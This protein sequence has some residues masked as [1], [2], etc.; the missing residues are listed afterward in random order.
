MKI[1]ITA[2]ITCQ[3][4]ATS[5]WGQTAPPKTAVELARYMGIDRERLLYDGAKKEGKVVWYTSLTVYKE[6]AR[7]FET[8]YPGVAVEVYRAPAMNLVSRI[9]SETQSRRSIVDAIETTPGSLMLVRDNKLLLPYNSPHL[10]DYPDGSKDKAP[11]GLFFTT[12][13]RESYAGIGYNKNVIPSA[14]VPKN[15]D[16]LLKPS[17]KGKLGI[18]G[19]EIGT[20]MIGAMLKEKGEGFV[21]KLAA[22]DIRHYAL[23]ALGLN[24]LVVSGEVPL[25]FTAVDS[26]VR[27]A[28]GRG[29]P[30]AWLP[31][32]LVPTNAGSLA[33]LLNTQRPHAALLFIDFVIGP[34]GQKLLSEKFGYGSPRKEHGFKRWYPEQG[35]SSYE[36]AQTIERWHKVLLQITLK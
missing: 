9:L 21:K 30:V 24:E 19:E 29:A 1:F 32:D 12:V 26:N 31:G 3:I 22:Q 5:V 13:D 36:Y 10:A 28:A 33:A 34:E 20:R 17:L 25:T 18:S 6:V 27:L 14:S 2:I 8:K 4:L 15:F 16:D 7:A 35:L 11:G 23:P